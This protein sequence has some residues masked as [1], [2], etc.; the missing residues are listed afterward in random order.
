M[1]TINL[2]SSLFIILFIIFIVY[3]ISNLYPEFKILNYLS[4]IVN[5]SANNNE[6]V[7]SFASHNKEK[8]KLLIKFNCENIFAKTSENNSCAIKKINCL[9]NSTIFKVNQSFLIYAT[10]NLTYIYKNYLN[11]TNKINVTYNLNID[12]NINLKTII[13]DFKKN[14]ELFFNSFLNIY[15]F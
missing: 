14:N 11:I 4:I 1:K 2:I 6:S 12:K 3:F 7:K 15:C 10:N 5:S 8:P 13:N 9:D